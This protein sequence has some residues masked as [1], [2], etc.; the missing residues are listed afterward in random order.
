M[1]NTATEKALTIKFIAHGSLYCGKKKALLR[2]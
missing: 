1:L 2:D